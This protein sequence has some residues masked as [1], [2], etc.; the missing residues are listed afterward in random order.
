MTTLPA[1]PRAELRSHVERAAARDTLVVQPR[2]GMTDPDAMGSG[3]GAVAAARACTVG[4]IT[5]DSYTRVGDLAVAE[6]AVREGLALNGYPIATHRPEVTRALLDR[7]PPDL[8]VQVRHGS[9]DPR[10]VFAAMDAAGL[11]ESEGG[12]VS[13]CLPYSRMPLREAA[14]AWSEACA[15]LAESAAARGRRAHL[16]T[17][18]GCMLG[19][20][21]PPS[22]LVALSLLE[23]LFFV[24]HGL[25]SISLSCAQ[26]THPIQDVEALAAL[27]TL[28]EEYLP[29]DV[30]WHLVL[31]TYMGVYP[32]TAAGARLLL[33]S[34]A[35]IAVRGGAHRLIVKTIAEAHRIPSVEENIEALEFA[36]GAAT[37]ARGEDCAL[38][39]SWEADC[40]RIHDE[41]RV[42]IEAALSA[43]SDVG[44]ALYRSFRRGVLDVP[45]CLHRD[46]AGRTR[47]AIAECGRLVWAE[48]GAMPLPRQANN[49][50]SVTAE[51][52]LSMLQHTA[53]AHDLG[54]LGRSVPGV[55]PE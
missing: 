10:R 44:R 31:Y 38:P 3:L 11:Y 25:R 28:A 53:R 45:Y 6:T 18:G 4:T 8:P 30:A 27:S 42:L 2:M 7:V 55:L 40:S 14:A 34:S 39:W 20:L 51:R 21:C 1:R 12:P 23:A 36:A 9:A 41:A 24:Q 46:N 52:L 17:F 19:Q 16:E 35:R 32:R 47:G 22:L 33:E 49:G 29:S 43:D 15:G 48:R 37:G 13:Y 50:V 54:A 26:Q 5:V